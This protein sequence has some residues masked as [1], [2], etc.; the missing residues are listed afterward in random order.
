MSSNIEEQIIEKLRM[1]PPEKKEEV[2]KFTQNLAGENQPRRMSIFE[3]IDAIVKQ[4]PPEAWDEVP[5]DGSLNV[6]H[7]LYGAPKRK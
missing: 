3:E 6:D 1:L 4:V 2:L 5:A 7:Y